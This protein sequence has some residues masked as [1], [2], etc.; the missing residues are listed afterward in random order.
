[1]VTVCSGRFLYA[2]GPEGCARGLGAA[3][4][5]VEESQPGRR[6]CARPRAIRAPQR[7]ETQRARE[8]ALLRSLWGRC[9]RGSGASERAPRVLG[10]ICRRGDEHVARTS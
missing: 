8:N 10:M 6:G 3:L 9:R 2:L 1:V 4:D 7:P 5:G